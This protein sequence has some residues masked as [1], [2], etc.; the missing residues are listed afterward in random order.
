MA[1]AWAQ[2]AGRLSN[3]GPGRRYHWDRPNPKPGGRRSAAGGRCALP[4]GRAAPACLVLAGR[5]GQEPVPKEPP[6]AAAVL[7]C[8]GCRVAGQGRGSPCSCLPQK[9]LP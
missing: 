7:G 4:P 9:P 5:G 8:T 2:L 3:R 6:P 1:R